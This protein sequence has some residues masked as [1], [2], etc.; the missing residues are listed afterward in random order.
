MRNTVNEPARYEQSSDKQVSDEKAI[1]AAL[2]K[3]AKKAL[4]RHKLTGY[5]IYFWENDQVVRR[6]AK[7]LKVDLERCE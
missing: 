7:D 4:R 2:E 6:E 5:P 3:A 1:T